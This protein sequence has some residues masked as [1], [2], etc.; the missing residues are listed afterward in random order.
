MA[1]SK[2][3][4]IAKQLDALNPSVPTR[5]RF[6]QGAEGQPDSK[7]PESGGSEGARK[8]KL[9][10][11]EKSN[12]F[13]SFF[14]TPEIFRQ[15]ASAAEKLRSFWLEDALRLQNLIFQSWKKTFGIIYETMSSNFVFAAGMFLNS[16]RK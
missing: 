10:A 1:S 15:N 3:I 6:M 7:F 5:T 9:S 4:D 11:F 14:E 12:V 8:D 16:K 2:R 13:V